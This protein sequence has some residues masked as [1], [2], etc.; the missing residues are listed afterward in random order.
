MDYTNFEECKKK[1]ENY[2]ND[3]EHPFLFISYKRDDKEKVYPFVCEL[4]DKGVNIW[5]DLKNMDENIG[6]SWQ[7]PAMKAIEDFGCRGII[8]FASTK[9]F[10]SAA[11]LAEL[12]YS[13]TDVPK[14]RHKVFEIM[15]VDIDGIIKSKKPVNDFI[16]DKYKELNHELEPK[17]KS[18]FNLELFGMDED[19]RKKF[20]SKLKTN[21]E[22]A[23]KIAKVAKLDDV[24][25]ILAEKPDQIV[26]TCTKCILPINPQKPNETE[27]KD[28]K[29]TTEERPVDNSKNEV[30]SVDTSN[31]L[32]AK[33]DYICKVI[34]ECL[35]NGSTNLTVATKRVAGRCGVTP[36][37]V[38][39]KYTRR[40][41]INTNEFEQLLKNYVKN[42]DREI[43]EKIKSNNKEN[44]HDLIDKKFEKLDKLRKGE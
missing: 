37:T 43:V 38:A 41:G 1:L 3:V 34:E 14:G 9:S 11:C 6:N 35:E 16:F 10:G 32:P 20:L 33:I 31:E 7:K 29:I 25:T 18:V 4:I 21:Y 36:S 19:E 2:E 13:Q 24:N 42:G 23:I 28:K 15:S 39:D 44:Y 40:L 27:T 17:D 30:D 12:L 22:V 8:F 26:A 5:I